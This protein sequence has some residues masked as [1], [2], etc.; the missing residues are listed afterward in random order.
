M[1]QA[2]ATFAHDNLIKQCWPIPYLSQ[3]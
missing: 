3:I 1:D 2:I